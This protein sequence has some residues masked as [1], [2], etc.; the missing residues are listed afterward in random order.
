MGFRR[1]GP[2][3]LLFSRLI[4]DYYVNRTAVWQHS[5][6]AC[7]NCISSMV[8]SIHFDPESFELTFLRVN[9]SYA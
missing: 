8:L 3:A 2:M 6:I 7:D 1:H 4:D 5:C 9:C